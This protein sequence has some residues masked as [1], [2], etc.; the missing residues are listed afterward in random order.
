MV[1]PVTVA[2]FALAMMA[3]ERVRPGRVLPDVPGWMK[4]VVCLD[5]V[6]V[7]TVLLFARFVEPVVTSL[8]PWSAEPLGLIGGSVL[9]Y[10]ALT[11]VFYWW[12]RWRHEVPF[13]WRSL[14]QVHH[15]PQRMEILTS[16]YKHPLEILVNAVISSVL[17]VPVLGLTGSQAAGAVLVAAVAELFYHWNVRTPRWLG[18]LIQRPEAHR[19]HHGAGQHA[20]NY[21]DL[22]LWDWLFGTL[23]DP[24]DYPEAV[25]FP[26]E[27]HRLLEMLAMQEVVSFGEA[28]HPSTRA[29]LRAHVTPSR[30]AAA[31]LALGLLAMAGDTLKQPMLTG[32]GLATGAAPLPKVFTTRD[33][34]EGFS[35]SFEVDYSEQGERHTVVLTPEDYAGLQ[36]P[37]ARRNPYGAALAGGP[38]LAGSDATRPMLDAVGTW[39]FCRPHVGVLQELGLA[40]EPHD[41]VVRVVPREGAAPTSLPLVLEAPCS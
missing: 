35:A 15:S 33:G 22:P 3:V 34:L 21:G 39:S 20:F 18:L 17:L 26:G 28:P 14:H 6:Q 4:R 24:E 19:L 7:V 16:F 12:H 8:R 11:F 41:V 40:V 1:V 2:V 37:Y 32:L 30:R 10:L 23:L 9:G 13:L 31:L 25:G 29:A 36:G 27:E 5:L 38:F